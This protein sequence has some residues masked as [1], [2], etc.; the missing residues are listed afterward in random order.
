M[1]RRGFS[2]PFLAL[3]LLGLSFGSSQAMISFGYLTPEKAKELGLEIR[4]RAAG[5]KD[6]WVEVSFPTK[7]PWKAFE[8]P[9]RINYVEL[10]LKKEGGKQELRTTLRENRTDRKGFVSVSF[11][12]DRTRLHQTSIWI[13]RRITDVAEVVRMRDF[14]A[15]DSIGREFKVVPRP[16]SDQ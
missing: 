1:S 12:V 3:L 15:L 6:V 11:T 9:G 2:I 13:T 10:G 14:V 5:P 4:Y 8:K 7:G 16:A